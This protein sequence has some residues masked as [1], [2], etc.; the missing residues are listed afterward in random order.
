MKR[1]ITVMLVLVAAG[2][3]AAEAFALKVDFTKEEVAAAGKHCVHGYTVNVTTV[4]A[5]FAG[6]AA[7]F[8]EQLST[9][10]KSKHELQQDATFATKKVVL[11]PGPMVVSRYYKPE[12]AISTDWSVTTWPEDRSNPSKV[13][14]Q[15]D[16][17]LGGQIKL[18]ELRIP[19]DFEVVSGGEIEKFVEGRKSKSK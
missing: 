3:F 9:L 2:M 7:S 5:F 10:G 18:E 1:W 8:N 12:R 19:A 11:H 16:I 13:H 14:L 4:V 6:D 15:I 17:W